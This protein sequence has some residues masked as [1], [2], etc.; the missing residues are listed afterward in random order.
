MDK[1][2]RIYCLKRWDYLRKEYYD[3]LVILPDDIELVLLPSNRND[4]D[5]MVVCVQCLKH[6]R[7]GST[8]TSLEVHTDMGLGY[9]VC[10]ECHGYETERY[11]N[12][13]QQPSQT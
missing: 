7:F 3:Y 12:Y 5:A 1:G 9:P 2:I 11:N 4:M 8:Y 10:E 6:I 13:R